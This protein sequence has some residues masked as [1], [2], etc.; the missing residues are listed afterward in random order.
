MTGSKVI[1][2]L[3]AGCIV[4]PNTDVRVMKLVGDRDHSLVE[5]IIAR[6]IA[7]NKQNRRPP[8]IESVRRRKA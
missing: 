5:A 7:A 4:F 3:D 1:Q 8:G 6:F 2:H